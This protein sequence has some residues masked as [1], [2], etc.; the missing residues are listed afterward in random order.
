MLIPEFLLVGLEVI[1]RDRPVTL[2]MRHSIR[3]PIT[4]PARNYEVGLTPEGVELAC[5]FG[6]QLAGKFSPGRITSSPVGRCID[7]ANAIARGA[8]WELKSQ[9]HPLLSH[10][11]IAPAWELYLAGKVNGHP[12]AQVIHTLRYL[13]DHQT[14]SPNLDI[15]VTHDTVVGA[16][17]GSLLHRPVQAEFWPAFLEGAFFWL[18][19]GIV[20][21]FWRGESHQLRHR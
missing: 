11:H 3:F 19:D 8:G 2:L 10:E 15:C 13:L 7:T 16:V 9:P 21:A 20:Q 18:E 17:V 1:P 4:D 14:T 6:R 12:P 5:E